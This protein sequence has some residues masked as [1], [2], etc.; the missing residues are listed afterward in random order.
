MTQH[1]AGQVN[2][3]GQ[4]EFVITYHAGVRVRYM[5]KDSVDYDQRVKHVDYR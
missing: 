1:C 3:F 5:K 2:F 4:I